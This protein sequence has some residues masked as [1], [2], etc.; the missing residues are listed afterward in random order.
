MSVA[1]IVTTYNRPDA[2][3]LVLKSVAE[4]GT[5]P[6]E[7]I[8]ADD[9]SRQET[10]EI[11]DDANATYLK[12]CVRHVWHE[13]AGFRAAKIRNEAIRIT[14]CDYLIFI[15]G[16][17]VLDNDFVADHLRFAKKGRFLQGSRVLFSKKYTELVLGGVKK[18]SRGD[19]LRFVHSSNLKNGFRLPWISRL[20]PAS[21][22]S[23]KGAR[24][25]N[26]SVY[27]EDIVRVGGFEEAFIGWG[28]EDTELSLRL[29]NSGLKRKKL[30]FCA[31]Q[32]HLWHFQED[33]NALKQNNKLLFDAM[34]E[35][36]VNAV[37]GINK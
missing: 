34:V 21:K 30:R 25:C 8:I 36:R 6:D 18:C 10:R 19:C 2:L 14:S 17:V 24:T 20:L 4:Q 23:V 35:Q 15:D 28:R 16:D 13:D 31:I 22:W 26:F 29:I 1:L 11:I 27:R 5:F 7:V 37:H 3:F 9:G 12:G 33:R 32:F